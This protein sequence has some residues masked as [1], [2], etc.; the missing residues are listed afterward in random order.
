MRKSERGKR[1]GLAKGRDETFGGEEHV[2]YHEGGHGLMG[3]HTGKT[4]QMVHFKYVRFLICQLHLNKAVSE[5][6]D[7][8]T[9]LCFY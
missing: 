6:H 1:K 8:I 4:Y 2:H 9:I 5:Q 3:V 7:S